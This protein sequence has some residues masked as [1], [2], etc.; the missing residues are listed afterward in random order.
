MR[1]SSAV[2]TALIA[3]IA[4]AGVGLSSAAFAD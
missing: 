4:L 2:R 1:L 3:T